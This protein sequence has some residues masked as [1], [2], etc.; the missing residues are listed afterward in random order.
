MSK[1]QRLLNKTIY[2]NKLAQVSLNEQLL[3]AATSAISDFKSWSFRSMIDKFVGTSESHATGEWLDKSGLSNLEGLLD[4]LTSA[5]EF[6]NIEAI[7]SALNS[8]NSLNV[9]T[10]VIPLSKS[11]AWA[12]LK[13]SLLAL[14]QSLQ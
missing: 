12:T 1:Y 6:R 9:Q 14:N 11:T 10:N 8:F 7:K 13:K 4:R 3:S 5:I 2:F